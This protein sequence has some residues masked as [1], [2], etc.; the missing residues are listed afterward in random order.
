MATVWPGGRSEASTA[1]EAIC[2]R[3][4]EIWRPAVTRV[5][6]QDAA[7]VPTAEPSSQTTKSASAVPRSG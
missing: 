6:R 4:S 3:S 5:Y 2:R 1:L 7:T